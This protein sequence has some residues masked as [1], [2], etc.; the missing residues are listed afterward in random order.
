MKSSQVR[1]RN[2]LLTWIFLLEQFTQSPNALLH[3]ESSRFLSSRLVLVRLVSSGR[4]GLSSGGWSRL[5]GSGWSRLSGSGWSSLNSSRR[6]RLKSSGWSRSCK[7]RNSILR[8]DVHGAT[9][10]RR[11]TRPP[12]RRLRPPSSETNWR[13]SRAD[14]RRLLLWSL[15]MRSRIRLSRLLIDDMSKTD[16]H[17]RQ[18][19]PIVAHC[20]TGLACDGPSIAGVET[21]VAVRR[22]ECVW[23]DS[24]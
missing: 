13:R 14:W 8:D 9:P 21:T 24:V 2:R 11:T 18:M 5:S 12:L 20:L 1:W 15:T 7:A 3:S 4:S 22:R 16:R 6:T 17:L 19:R 10:T 23:P